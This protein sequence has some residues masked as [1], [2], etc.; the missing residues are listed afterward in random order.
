MKVPWTSS[1]AQSEEAIDIQAAA[2]AHAAD[3]QARWRFRLALALVAGPV[4]AA[5]LL[6]IVWSPVEDEQA[7]KVAPSTPVSISS[8]PSACQPF[9]HDP[10]PTEDFRFN[11]WNANGTEVWADIRQGRG[12]I[13]MRARA[14]ERADRAQSWGESE[15]GTTSK[16]G[17]ARS[18]AFCAEAT[19]VRNILLRRRR[20]VCCERMP[21]SW[22]VLR[23]RRTLLLRRAM[24]S[25]LSSPCHRWR[26]LLP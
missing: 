24:R 1:A 10:L 23:Q 5:L 17:E 2:L 12:T 9:V 3:I 16:K 14:N 11:E 4:A 26:S 19:R 25:D 22:A 18:V 20:S 21:T 7:A 15:K 13:G 6:L 8:R